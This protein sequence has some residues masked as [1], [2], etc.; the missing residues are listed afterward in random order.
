MFNQEITSL[1]KFNFGAK[2]KVVATKK[3][4]PATKKE[5]EQTPKKPTKSKNTAYVEAEEVDVDLEEELDWTD[6]LLVEVLDEYPN[7]YQWL[8]DEDELSVG[9]FLI[10]A[11]RITSNGP[12]NHPKS[13]TQPNNNPSHDEE[14]M[15]TNQTY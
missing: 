7:K 12:S 2:S 11:F 1:V 10:A 13:N 5:K 6:T 9:L 15:D 14:E 8:V 4:T 3:T